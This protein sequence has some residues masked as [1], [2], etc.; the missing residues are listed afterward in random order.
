MTARLTGIARRA[1]PRA[2]METLSVGTVSVA[3]GL[4]GDFRGKNGHRQVT[5]I[6]AQDWEAACHVLGQDLSWTTRRA[7]L[8]VEG[9]SGLEGIKV[10]GARLR[11]GPVLLEVT[12]E[13]EPC[14]RM[15]AQ[16]QGLREALK[17]DWR[18]GIC[19]KVLEGGTIAL[20][21]AVTIEADAG[22]ARISA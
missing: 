17:P 19:C 8:L 14:S 1:Q 11:V 21:A 6:F 3:A 18:G 4:E 15:D 2:A 22:A 20:G 16:A 13:T 5:V 9:L 12:E 7:N 10:L